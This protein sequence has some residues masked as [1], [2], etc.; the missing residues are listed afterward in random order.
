MHEDFF[1]NTYGKRDFSLARGKGSYVWDEDGKKYLD[2]VTGISVNALGHC[3]DPVVRAIK[4]QLDLFSH[5]SNLYLMKSQQELGKVLVE[6]TPLDRV[7]FCNS[8]TE[9]VEAAIKFVRKYWDQKGNNG[10][11]EIIS[12]ENSFHGRTYGALAATG[13][14]ALKQGFGPFPEGFTCVP[15]NNQEALKEAV[16]SRTAAVIAEPV[17]AE[18]GVISLEPEFISVLSQ[19]QEKGI[20]LICDEIQTGLGRAG[21][22]LASVGMGL[23]PD[24]VTLAKALGGGLPL[25]AVLVKESIAAC[26]KKGDHGSTFGGN[27]VACAAGLE[28]L[29]SILESGFLSEVRERSDYLRNKLQTW[30][31]SH[32]GSG[33]SMPV[34]GRGFL[35][36]MHYAGNL[37]DFM[38]AC[39]KQGLLLYRAGKEIIRLLPPLNI[40]NPEMDEVVEKMDKAVVQLQKS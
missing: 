1:I 5:G 14:E 29:R 12:F 33:F 37:D 18:G 3:Y 40:S 15:V 38:L 26:L 9:A 11:Y 4:N 39:R 13:Q 19:L 17:L 21:E 16:T 32:P 8:G 30:A 22:L 23:R 34:L 24:V 7:F 2:C 31:V 35:I 28:V 10:R 25:G 27:P 36:G 20:L 6:N